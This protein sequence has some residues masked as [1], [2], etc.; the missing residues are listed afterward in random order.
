MDDLKVSRVLFLGEQDGPVERQL[1][2]KLIEHCFVSQGSV[3]SAYLARVSYQD[4]PGVTVALS[5]WGG[6][7]NAAA[8]LECIGTAFRPLFRATEHLDTVFL[9]ELQRQA[10]DKVA[11]PF[12]VAN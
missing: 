5:L 10:V 1:K 4:T 9:D 7:E 6:K 12:Y 3:S 11:K 2:T 8:I